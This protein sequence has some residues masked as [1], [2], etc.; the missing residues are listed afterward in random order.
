MG[1]AA[2]GITLPEAFPV[3]NGEGELLVWKAQ[4][5]CRLRNWYQGEGRVGGPVDSSRKHH[6]A[7]GLHGEVHCELAWAS[8]ETHSTLV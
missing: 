7:S 2:G 8:C 6:T 3:R 5:C 1:R 4:P